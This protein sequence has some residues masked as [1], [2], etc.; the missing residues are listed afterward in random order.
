MTFLR[1]AKV[2]KSDKAD[3]H[4]IALECEDKEQIKELKVKTEYE[5]LPQLFICCR[6]HPYKSF[7]KETS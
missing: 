5:M 3:L 2:I 1:F 7:Y 6:R 4:I